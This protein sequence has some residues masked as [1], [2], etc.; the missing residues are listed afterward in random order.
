MLATA[1]K[2]AKLRDAISRSYLPIGRLAN[3][4]CATLC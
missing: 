4:R 3:S 1:D 2:V